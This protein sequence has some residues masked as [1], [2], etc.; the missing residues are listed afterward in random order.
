MNKRRYLSFC[1]LAFLMLSLLLAACATPTPVVEVVKETVMVEATVK[2]VE[3]VLITPTP[4][5]VVASTT[6]SK[7]LERGFFYVGNI[8]EPPFSY[9]NADGLLVGIDA[10]IARYIANELG[11]KELVSVHTGWDGLIPGL[12][13]GRTDLLAVGMAIRPQR[14]E[15]VTFTNPYHILAPTALVKKGNPFDIHS[16]EDM[17]THKD[18]IAGGMSG[19]VDVEVLRKYLPEE[20]IR[21][22]DEISLAF[23][24]LKA[25]RL[26]AVIGTSVSHKDWIK[27]A[28]MEDKFE[29][30]T[31]WEWPKDYLIPSALVFRKEDQALADQATE[32]LERMKADGTLTKLA[33]QNNFPV[34]ALAPACS[35]SEI[36][37]FKYYCP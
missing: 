33:E 10:D 15:V 8:Q 13:A 14:C 16:F 28:G 36:G 30:A 12:L 5:P 21:S 6:L 24:D 23:E 37:C 11:V 27:G 32:I 4:E 18:L 7:A 20:Q 22:Y 2:V 19:S 17:A 34:E 9:V 1:A 26:D 3:E 31:P 35:E 29:L 25:G